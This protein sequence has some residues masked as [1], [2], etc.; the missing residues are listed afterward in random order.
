MGRRGKR[1]MKWNDDYVEWMEKKR[2]HHKSVFMA[3]FQLKHSLA[4]LRYDQ[5]KLKNTKRRNTCMSI[6]FIIL[7]KTHNVVVFCNSIPMLKLRTFFVTRIMLGVNLYG[8][9]N[10][11]NMK[12]RVIKVCTRNR[13]HN[14]SNF[15]T[16]CQ[17]LTCHSHPSLNQSICF[18]RYK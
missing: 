9:L 15:I 10:T 1:E 12:I 14:T 6:L 2:E 4:H 8:H 11:L 18:V 13:H 17:K 16:T 5:E 3:F 7:A